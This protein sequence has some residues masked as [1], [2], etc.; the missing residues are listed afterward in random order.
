L[1]LCYITDRSQLS[2]NESVR[3]SLLLE[4][5]AEAARCGVDCIQLREKDLSPR[6]LE[7][8]SNQALN[9]IRH[10]TAHR[11]AATV[12]STRLLINSRTDVAASVGA[13]GV[14]LRSDDISPAQ[15]REIW[16]LS[17][18]RH[19]PPLISVSCHSAAEVDRA[20]S[21]AAD[22]AIFGPVFEKSGSEPAGLE[23]LRQACRSKIA[24]L[25]LGGVTLNSAASC[26]DAGAAGIAGIRLFQENSIGEVVR[27]L[28]TR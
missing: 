7:I 11:T 15:A 25:A 10:V 17:A 6:E 2:G 19:F 1:F 13:H 23:A 24:V 8:L 28:R 22:L 4:K 12:A 20:A 9:T 16:K 14:H 26:M 5:I 27:A 3:R 18:A 21:E